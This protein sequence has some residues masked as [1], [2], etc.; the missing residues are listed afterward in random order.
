M[1]TAQELS[2]IEV[3]KL[4]YCYVKDQIDPQPSID[5]KHL[6]HLHPEDLVNDEIPEEL[7]VHEEYTPATVKHLLKL[8]S[9]VIT[10]MEDKNIDNI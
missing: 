4:I 7:F 5:L 8:M 10:K 9:V 2:D 1:K 3:M 6:A